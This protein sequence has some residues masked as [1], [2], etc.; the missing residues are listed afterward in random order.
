MSR[1]QSDNVDD[2]TRMLRGEFEELDREIR[3]EQMQPFLIR[4]NQCQSKDVFFHVVGNTLTIYCD[5]CPA[6]Q[7]IKLV[8]TVKEEKP[9]ENSFGPLFDDLK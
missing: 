2:F 6:N 4:C 9:T 8:S 5:H 3:R 7:T 1:Y